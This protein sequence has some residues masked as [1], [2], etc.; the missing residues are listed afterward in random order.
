MPGTGNPP[1]TA[2]G[3]K[4]FPLLQLRF[5]VEESLDILKRFL[6]L[7]QEPGKIAGS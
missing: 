3:P 7:F 1:G 4:K 5:V 6:H 2:A